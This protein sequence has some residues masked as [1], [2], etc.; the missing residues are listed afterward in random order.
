MTERD[1]FFLEHRPIHAY[2]SADLDAVW[3]TVE[4]DLP[5]L[6]S[7]VERMLGRAAAAPG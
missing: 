4:Q 3:S 2:F 5:V 1:G 7:N 6:R